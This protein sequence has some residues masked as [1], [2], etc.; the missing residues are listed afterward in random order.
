MTLE[1]LIYMMKTER[2]CVLLAAGE[3]R[4]NPNNHDETPTKCTRDCAH[5]T[6]V[7]DDKELIEAYDDV[8]AMLE[9]KKPVPVTHRCG[10]CDNRLGNTDLFCSMCGRR[11]KWDDNLDVEQE[12]I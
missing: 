1:S 2:K 10:Y 11:L 12:S 8:I 9:L 7:Q 3:W 5:C 6:I 4:E